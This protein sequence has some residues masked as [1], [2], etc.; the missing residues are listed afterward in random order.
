MNV[1]FLTFHTINNQIPPPRKKTRRICAN[2]KT[3]IAVGWL[4]SSP[5]ATT[6]LNFISVTNAVCQNGGGHFYPNPSRHSRGDA[7]GH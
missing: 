3:R 5:L 6:P 4:G 1:D 2:L 7:P